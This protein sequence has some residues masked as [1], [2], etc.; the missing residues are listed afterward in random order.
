MFKEL[1]GVMAQQIK[2]GNKLRN[3]KKQL[4]FLELSSS[5]TEGQTY[6]GGSVT[7][8]SLYNKLQT[9]GQINTHHSI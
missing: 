1:Q 6:R 5:I 2:N 3:A 8:L 7:A 9:L 4:R